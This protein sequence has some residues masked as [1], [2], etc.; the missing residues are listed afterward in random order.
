MITRHNVF[1]TDPK[2]PEPAELPN[3][4]TSFEEDNNISITLTPEIASRQEEKEDRPST[5]RSSLEIVPIRTTI[6]RN[7]ED[8]LD[9]EDE[10][11]RTPF[12][13]HNRVSGRPS[14]NNVPIRST[15]EKTV[16][17]D[18][19]EVYETPSRN[20]E[21]VPIKSKTDRNFQ[22]DAKKLDRENV[23]PVRSRSKISGKVCC[24]RVPILIRN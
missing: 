14:L 17:K 1:A 11:F 19:D 8:I 21:I 10:E 16:A 9:D 2:K 13:N 23:N 18:L 6:Q 15:T 20:L 3:S 22:N 24:V 7:L 12:R 5:L 4:K